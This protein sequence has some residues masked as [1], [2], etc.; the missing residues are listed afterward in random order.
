MLNINIKR[1]TFLVFLSIDLL[2]ILNLRFG[3]IHVNKRSFAGWPPRHD[4]ANE[5]W[6]LVSWN[7]PGLPSC[8]IKTS[9]VP[10]K[11]TDNCCASLLLLAHHHWRSIWCFDDYDTLWLN[12]QSSIV[13]NR[14]ESG[15]GLT[16]KLCAQRPINVDS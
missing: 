3:I 5:L 1:D 11:P 6:S 16:Q 4:A 15:G 9:R 2:N 8:R 7:L 12:K 10:I 13:W 14:S